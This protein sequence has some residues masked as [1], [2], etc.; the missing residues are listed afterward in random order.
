MSPH[1]RLAAREQQVSAAERTMGENLRAI[2][3]AWLGPLSPED[4]AMLQKVTA[5]F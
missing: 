1:L 5:W 3:E 4:E 2:A